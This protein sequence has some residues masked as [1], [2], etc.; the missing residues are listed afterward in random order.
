VALV[1]PTGAGKSSILNLLL[2]LY[3][4]QRGRILIDGVDIREIPQRELRSQVGVVLQDVFL[5]SGTIADNIRL[6]SP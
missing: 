2:R 5:F 3:D 4:V 1:G 6:A